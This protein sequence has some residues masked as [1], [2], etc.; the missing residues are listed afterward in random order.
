MAIIGVLN[1]HEV[2]EHQALSDFSD[3][4]DPYVAPAATWVPHQVITTEVDTDESAH[5]ASTISRLTG[6]GQSPPG[7]FCG[8][9]IGPTGR[10]NK[11]GNL[12]RSQISFEYCDGAEGGI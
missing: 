3:I 1:T 11:K 9:Q 2:F 5:D 7:K 4:G 6:W 12:A 8:T 10:K